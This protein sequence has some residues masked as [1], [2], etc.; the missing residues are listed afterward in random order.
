MCMGM[1][2]TNTRGGGWVVCMRTPW[3]NTQGAGC[4]WECPGLILGELGGVFENV[5]D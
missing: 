3:T 5:M 4:V 2:W 1:S